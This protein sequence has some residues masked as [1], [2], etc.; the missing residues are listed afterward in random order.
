[1]AWVYERLVWLG[2]NIVIGPGCE[3]LVLE[4]KNETEAISKNY[5]GKMIGMKTF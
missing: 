2:D 3:F 1:M 5:P 4:N